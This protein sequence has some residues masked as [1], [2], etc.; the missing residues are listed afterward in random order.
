MEVSKYILGK[1]ADG[2]RFNV[3]LISFP[4]DIG[5]A[6]RLLLQPLEENARL[7]FSRQGA[8]VAH[9]QKARID[10]SEHIRDLEDTYFFLVRVVLYIGLLFAAIGF[11]YSSVLLRLLAG[12]Q[13]GSNLEASAALSAL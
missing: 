8:L 9:E 7:L 3:F 2:K 10:A 1:E 13:W 11:N 5:L 6:A 12:S 4:V